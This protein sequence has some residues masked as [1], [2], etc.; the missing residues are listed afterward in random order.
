MANV[1]DIINA[2]EISAAPL[3]EKPGTLTAKNLQRFRVAE[4]QVRAQFCPAP[5]LQIFILIFGWQQGL[6]W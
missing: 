1:A 4:R 6:R 5:R 2:V 3:V